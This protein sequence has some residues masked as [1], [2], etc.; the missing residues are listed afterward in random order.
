M[1]ATPTEQIV[2]KTLEY[3]EIP[4]V[5]GHEEFFMNYLA[6]EYKRMKLNV[7]Q[8]DS[9]LVVSG[10]EKYDTIISAHI[11]RHGLMSIGYGEYAYAGQYVREIKYG[12]NDRTSHRNLE[13]ISERFVDE[14]VY[15]YDPKTIKTMGY[16]TITA[17]E[18]HL[19]RNG[20]AIFYVEG[21]DDL[22]EDIPLAYAKKGRNHGGFLKGQIDNALSVAVIHTLFANGFQGTAILTTEEEIGK[23]WSHM[24]DF[25]TE[26]KID[27]DKLLILDTS[28]Y[29]V[30]RFVND[31]YIILRNR[32]KSAKFNSKLAH[33]IAKYCRKLSLP[34]HFKDQYLL[35]QGKD[36]PDLGSTELGR[37][38]MGT[39]QQWTGTS[40]Q[41]PTLAYHTS[42]ETTTHKAIKNFY[43]LLDNILIKKTFNIHEDA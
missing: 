9:V 40:I 18:A 36:I 26:E 32:D 29:Q 35:D 12:Q 37:L 6:R 39:A 22:P 2:Q 3:L 25:L 24:Q 8:W 31:G 17:C 16:G 21:M 4:A 10:R 13:S 7:E 28:P 30:H 38:I 20:D 5:V 34:F 14:A 1:T 43:T 42:Y 41:I 11:D 33:Q 19:R 15:A 23:S 27:T